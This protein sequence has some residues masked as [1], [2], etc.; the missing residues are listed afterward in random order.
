MGGRIDDFAVVESRPSTVYVATAAGG[1]WKT[2]NN[3][4]TL[5]PVFDDQEVSSIGD[6]AVAPSDPSIVYVGTGEPNN[7]QS[8]SWGNGVYKSLD[9]GKTWVHAGLADTRHIGRVVVHPTNPDVAYVAAL[10]HLWGPNKERGLFRTTDG[11]KTWVNTKFIDE[12]TGF[13]DV[14]MDPESP[15]TLYAASYQRRRTPFGYNGGGPGSA[16]WKT[17][18][19]GETW[20]KLSDGLPTSGD[21]GRIGIG[22]YRR[23]PRIVYALVEHAK[24]G[25]IFRS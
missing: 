18:N 5:E 22:I 1:L 10:G 25:G 20:T 12:D 3:G 8:S 19:G 13:V 11:G 15:Q 23:D 2:V 9:A 7:R 14:A 21:V 6:V 17:T 24:E 16:L 4:V